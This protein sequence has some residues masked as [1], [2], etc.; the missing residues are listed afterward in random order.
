MKIEGQRIREAKEQSCTERSGNEDEI[1]IADGIEK[2]GEG[3]CLMGQS[4]NDTGNKLQFTADTTTLSGGGI[5]NRY[6]EPWITVLPAL[7]ISV[8]LTAFSIYQTTATPRGLPEG[9]VGIVRMDGSLCR[10]N[11]HPG[12]LRGVLIAWSDSI[13]QAWGTVYE[14]GFI[15]Y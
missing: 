9:Y 11:I 2:V 10:I 14:P 6:T 3:I 13:F 8:F 5:R 15:P 4:I 1:G 12:G 7:I